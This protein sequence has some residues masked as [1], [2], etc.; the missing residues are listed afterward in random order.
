MIMVLQRE[1]KADYWR[2][3]KLC[4]W[5]SMWYMRENIT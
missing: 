1:M 5:E 2:L 3:G 4:T